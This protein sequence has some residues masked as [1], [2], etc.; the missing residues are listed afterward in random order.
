M[1][2]TLNTTANVNT[3]TGALATKPAAW[4]D[5]TLL[6][7]L[8][9]KEFKHEKLAQMRPMP[10]NSGDTIQFRKLTKLNPALTPLTEGVT[11]DGSNASISAISATTKQYGKTA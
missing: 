6:A 10:K 11:P 7:V 8:R 9:Q 4:Y 5:K 3:G 2:N 1:A